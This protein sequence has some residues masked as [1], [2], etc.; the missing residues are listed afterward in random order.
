MTLVA[1]RAK[2]SCVHV[3]QNIGQSYHES[4]AWTVTVKESVIG[5]LRWFGRKVA[6][7]LLEETTDRL[8][9]NPLEESRQMKSLRPNPFAERELRLHG[10]YRVLFDVDQKGETVTI[11]AIGEKRGNILLVQGE[12]FTE[13]ESDSAK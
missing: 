7:R 9:A 11:L 13:H 4:M 6:R 2:R 3:D 12:E 10:K 5:D 8:S 1:P